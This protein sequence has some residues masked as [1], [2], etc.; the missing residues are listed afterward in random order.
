MRRHL[1]PLLAVLLLPSQSS[2]ADVERLV[3]QLGSV[4]FEEREAASRALEKVGYPALDA[5]RKAA[6]SEDRETRRRAGLLV[7]QIENGLDALLVTYR[8]YGLPLPPEDAKLVR[9]VSGWTYEG[10]GR[11]STPRYALGFQLPP[12]AAP[13]P[14]RL[15]VGT[16]VYEADPGREKVEAVRPDA[17][18]LTAFDP[19]WARTPFEVNAGLAVAVQCHARGWGRL[20]REVLDLSLRHSAGH[21]FSMFRQPA[22][23]LP[24]DALAYL[25]W[26]HWGNEI[27][28][29]GTD[30]AVIAKRMKALLAARPGFRTPA[31][32]A[33]L[34][35]LEA[36][37]RPSRA[38]P[39]SVEALIDGL[40]DLPQGTY[41][42]PADSPY[43]GLAERG[44]EAVPVLIA[45]LDDERLTRGLKVGFNNF[46]TWHLRVQDLAS[47]LLQKLAG[48]NLGKDWVRRQQGYAVEK[49]AAQAWW[50]RARKQGEEAYLLAHILPAGRT[51]TFPNDH[52]LRV[53][54]KRYPRR[55]PGL[56]CTVL[57]ERPEME[58]WSLSEA[59]G[60][61]SLPCGEKVELFLR[62]SRHKNLEHRRAALWELKGLDQKVFVERLVET[63]ESLPTKP[64]GPYWK[65]REATFARLV[66]QTADPRAWRAL[67]RAAK[68]A[69]VGLRMEMLEGVGGDAKDPQRKERLAFL[70]AFLDD[71]T[72][73]DP[74]SDAKMFEGPHAASQYP[75]LEIRDYAAL[76]IATL[77]KLPE[78]SRPEWK[79]EEWAA[80]RAKVRE[81][82]KK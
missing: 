28:R 74:R 17:A 81:S 30:R 38:T 75:R 37:L 23:Q 4:R 9:V 73:R 20:A 42:Q 82:L 79:P 14:C 44:F 2:A 71:A 16:E 72:I 63:L 43:W 66:V 76:E 5:L 26:A 25:A 64:E 59:L 6:K 21:H 60:K 48:E 67:E 45:H 77:L 61:S 57:D 40:V 62:A 54:A 50:E 10:P 33:L 19:C 32:Q 69:D 47:D 31:N 15:L 3:K 7:Q 27:A 70:A 29:P 65:C 55:L 51:N 39:G 22:G 24:P 36:A 34:R 56:Y 80:L 18:D 68:R 8:E 53:I 1:I 11:D 13:G 12:Q 78:K 46:P 58:S 41:G 49:A 35:S 52:L